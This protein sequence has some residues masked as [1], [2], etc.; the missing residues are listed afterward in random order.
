MHVRYRLLAGLTAFG[1]TAAAAGLFVGQLTASAIDP[2]YR[3]VAARP[4]VATAIGLAPT[5]PA[6]ISYSPVASPAEW[7][8]AT[9]PPA[10][11]HAFREPAPVRAY[12]FVEPPEPSRFEVDAVAAPDP[13]R[14]AP[15][16]APSDDLAPPAPPSPGPIE[17]AIL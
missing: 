11:E 1:A 15:P 16:E 14:L 10:S 9:P 2:H 4:D 5:Q 12:E 17:P 6:P 7:P 13:A 8:D 3:E